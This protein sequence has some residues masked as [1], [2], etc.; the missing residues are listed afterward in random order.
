M[1]SESEMIEKTSS[2]YTLLSLF[3]KFPQLMR[4]LS[5]IGGFG[6]L[7][8]SIVVAQTDSFIDAETSP[9]A[10]APAAA[11][12][13]APAPVTAPS[14]AAAPAPSPTPAPAA[15]AP[16][17]APALVEA[18]LPAPTPIAA[19]AP[20]KSPLAAPN[21]YVPPSADIAQPSPPLVNPPTQRSAQTDLAPQNSYID[22]TDYSIGSTRRDNKPTSVILTE[23]S[24]GCST[25]SHNS[26]LSSSSC[27]VPTPNQGTANEKPTL[28]QP[29]PGSI[30]KRP[31][32][33]IPA[34]ARVQPVNN[35]QPVKTGA[36]RGKTNN[37]SGRPL[38]RVKVNTNSISRL[39][40]NPV[41][42]NTNVPSQPLNRVA[43][44]QQAKQSGLA[45][46]NLTNRPAGRPSIGKSQFMFP[47]TIPA[48]IGSVFGWRLD[49]FTGDPRFHSGTDIGAPLGT[50][51]VAAASGEVA[52]AD[53]AG[54]YGLMVI[55]RHEEN[56]Q[57][58]RYAHLS[59]IFVRPGEQVEL[60]NVIGRVGSTGRST[61]P[62]L[63]FEWRHLTSD[64]WVTVDAGDHLEYSLAQFIRALQVAQ[65]APQLGLENQVRILQ[66]P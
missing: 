43:V 56:T 62:H 34:I 57:E 14:P 65:A 19:P 22:N 17:A 32:L 1:S 53:F 51:V 26:Q 60:G 12:P 13:P 52:Y 63:H 29:Q 64:G 42:A 16:A 47:L 25:V 6:F 36:V 44:R 35:V 2:S 41:K 39:P 66:E 48:A 8:S 3:Y 50:P 28:R 9:P 23:R 11:A 31:K 20:K 4:V 24:T 15:A 7:S 55:M 33:P 59:E 45:Y 37:I 27:G 49:P 18:P 40:L 58:S 21:L 54:G 10:L 38:N 46:Y 5:L 30:T 61:G